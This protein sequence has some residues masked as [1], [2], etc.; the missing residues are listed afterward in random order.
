M[1]LLLLLLSL[2]LLSLLILLAER[3]DPV[4]GLRTQTGQAGAN[5][6]GCQHGP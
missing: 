1:L 2:L 3:V 4:K 5:G 6:E